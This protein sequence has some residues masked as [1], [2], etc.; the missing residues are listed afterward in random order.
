MKKMKYM[1]FEIF[2]QTQQE[3]QNPLPFFLDS[4]PPPKLVI[5]T[6]STLDH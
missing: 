1:Y 3:S 2:I 6:N 5:S 4:P